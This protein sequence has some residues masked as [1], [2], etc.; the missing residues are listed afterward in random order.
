MFSVLLFSLLIEGGLR[1]IGYGSSPRFYRVEKSDDGSR[2]YRENQSFAFP[3]FEKSV[4]RK[5]QPFRLAYT[6]PADEYRV[7]LLGSSAAMG[8]PE[9]SF[10]ISRVLELMLDEAY[11]DRDFKVVNAA[12]TAIN[13]H[14]VRRIAEDCTRLSP[15]LF[16]VYEGNNEVIGPFGPTGALTPFLGSEAMI[17]TTIRLRSSRTGQLISN[18]V[19]FGGNEDTPEGWGGMQMFLKQKVTRD[20]LRLDNVERL[21]VSNLRHIVRS[22]KSVGIPTFLCTVL[23]NQRDFAPFQSRHAPNVTPTQLKEWEQLINR[24][25]EALIDGNPDA[26]ESAYQQAWDIDNAYAALAYKLGRLYLQKNADAQAGKYLQLALDL[27]TLRF[28]TDSR[29]NQAICD[30]AAEGESSCSLVDL[31]TVFTQA[32]SHHIMGDEWLYEHVHLN[33]YTNYQIAGVLYEIVSDELLKSGKI[34]EKHPQ[35]LDY[36]TVGK[37]LGYTLY[38]QGLIAN[39]LLNRF[40]KPPFTAQIDHTARLAAWQERVEKI[41]RALSNP[42][43]R[44]QVIRDYQAAIDRRPADWILRRNFGMALLAFDR[45]D[46]A[47]PLLET[48]LNTINDDPDTLFALGVAYASCDRIAEARKVFEKLEKME[49]RYPGL[50]DWKRKLNSRPVH[51]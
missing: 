25:D 44:S 29:L 27:D 21:F 12:M 28:R 33:F 1:L 14:V 38:E 41:D 48:A 45:P 13:S 42:D 34:Q 51:S 36:E 49:P 2:I 8:D 40:Q 47:V 5:P 17:D 31:E 10:S 6:K 30:Q 32:S 16:I 39:E 37:T 35:R 23:T 4:M 19:A 43:V 46:R 18:L 3:Y 20:D 50:T 22:G 7:F 15:D 9:A 26:A 24:G 11:G